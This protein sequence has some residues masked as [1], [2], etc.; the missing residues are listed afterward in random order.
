MF[1]FMQTIKSAFGALQLS[2]NYRLVLN[3]SST[4]SSVCDPATKTLNSNHIILC[5]SHK[6][7]HYKK[8]DPMQ[9]NCHRD[10]NFV[11][12]S[13]STRYESWSQAIYFLMN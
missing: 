10:N 7:R 9:L 8:F 2:L 13:V 6:Y 11:A 1:I 12:Q 5:E 3:A 4:T